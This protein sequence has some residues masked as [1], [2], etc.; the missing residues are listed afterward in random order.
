MQ[1]AVEVLDFE[2]AAQIRDMMLEVKALD[3]G[4]SMIYLRKL[5]KEDLMSL[6]EMAYSQL[7]PVWKQYD[8]PYYDD[9]QYFQILK[10]SNY[11]NQNPF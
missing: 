8:A 2:L 1:E 7:N 4:N 11:K 5:K 6:W 9:Y 3:Q 10:N